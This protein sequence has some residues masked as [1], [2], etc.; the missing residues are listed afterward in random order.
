[1]Q[2]YARL[3]FSLQIMLKPGITTGD[4][5]GKGIARPE[6]MITAIHWALRLILPH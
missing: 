1:V 3:E 5:T 2:F 6:S 4:P